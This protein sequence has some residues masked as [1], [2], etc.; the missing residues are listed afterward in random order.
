MG[1]AKLTPE[2]QTAV[3]QWAAEGANL[4]EVQQ[5]LKAQFDLSMTYLDARLLMVDL[6]LKLK[7]KERAKE[8]V[9]APAPVI[10]EGEAAAPGS[11]A[12]TVTLDELAIE[13]AMCSGKVTFSD[14][15][16]AGWYI[17]QQG[18]LGMKA[19]EPGY[20]PPEADVPVFQEE[21]ERV[22]A[23]AGL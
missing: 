15:K 6:D 1:M 13:G 14:G 7:E 4:N 22:L 8:P 9:P 11:G 3:E 5:R 10:G 20:K 12:V 21:L 18:R 23:A 19:P 17:D 16:I 2:Q